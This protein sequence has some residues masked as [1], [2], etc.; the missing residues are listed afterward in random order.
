MVLPASESTSHVPG[1]STLTDE[2]RHAIEKLVFKSA[3]NVRS[4]HEIAGHQPNNWPWNIL[5]AH[6]CSKTRQ[7]QKAKNTRNTC[8]QYQTGGGLCTERMR[9]T[10]TGVGACS[11]HM[12]SRRCVWESL[13]PCVRRALVKQLKVSTWWRCVL[14]VCCTQPCSP[15]S[16]RFP[17][18]ALLPKSSKKCCP[19]T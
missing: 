3:T 13:P 5:L 2:S 10:N 11:V 12:F 19:N 18:A 14:L 15:F 4:W 9:T 8:L 1:Q 7:Y 6:Q 17:F 16:P